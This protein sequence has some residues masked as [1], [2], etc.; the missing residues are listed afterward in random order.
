MRQHHRV[1]LLV[2]SAVVVL[3]LLLE[4]RADQRVAFCF[5]PDHPLPHTCLARMVFESGCPGCG[6]TRSLIQLA[7]GNWCAAFAQHRLGWL[8]AGTILL[9]FPYRV[10]ALRQADGEMPGSSA[11]RYAGFVLVFLLVANWLLDIVLLD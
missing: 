1:Y 9:Q 3:A 10:L 7:H 11:V 6:L 2:S 8:M 4:V 5:L